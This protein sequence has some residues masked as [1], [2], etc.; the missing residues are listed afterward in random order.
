MMHSNRKLR[1]RA[2]TLADIVPPGMEVSGE[3]GFFLTVNVISLL[4][5]MRYLT[6][7]FDARDALYTDRWSGTAELIPGAVMEHFFV[8]FDDA[9]NGFFF[10]AV[11]ML[12]FGV[13]HYTY[14]YRGTKSIYL[15]RRLP[16]RRVLFLRTWTL[17][18]GEILICLLLA[19]LC[20]AVSF[21]WY[22][23]ITPGECL[24]A[25]EWALFW[26]RM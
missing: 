11:C 19:A 3:L 9:W 14:Y 26:N 25:G 22:L 20:L 2:R 21:G 12:L 15:M 18:A 4:Y 24:P 6:R 8:L 1:T 5:S 13:R 7:L 23:Y 10:A 17:P 16:D